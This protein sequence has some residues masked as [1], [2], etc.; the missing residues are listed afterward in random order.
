MSRNLTIDLNLIEPDQPL[1]QGDDRPNEL[2]IMPA[3][4]MCSMPMVQID[5]PPYE[6]QQQYIAASPFASEMVNIS[7]SPMYMDASL[8][9]TTPTFPTPTYFA[10][11][12]AYVQPGIMTPDCFGTPSGYLGIPMADSIPVPM[13]D[14][15]NYG[16]LHHQKYQRRSPHIA[17]SCRVHNVVKRVRAFCLKNDIPLIKIVDGPN[18]LKISVRSVLH[19]QKVEKV[20]T[21]IVRIDGI[22]VESVSL[23]ESIDVTKRKRGFLLFMN[24]QDF[25]KDQAQVLKRFAETGLDYKIT[26]V[27]GLT[28]SAGSKSRKHDMETLLKKVELLTL[29]VQKLQD[30][31]SS[32]KQA[33]AEEPTAE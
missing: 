24:I 10:P 29:T 28:H 1:Q 11:S 18:V 21:N 6:A 13:A 8:M 26:V 30:D 7:A 4:G 14:T 17:V 22:K 19:T 23:P 5:N 16:A 12:P 31:S 33:V 15:P 27:D 2:P 9:Y 32:P 3:N 20:L 25:E